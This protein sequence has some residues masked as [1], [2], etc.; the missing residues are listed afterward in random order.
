MMQLIIE[1]EQQSWKD[2]LQRPAPADQGITATVSAILRDI[3]LN[4]D[5]ALRRYTER[6]DGVSPDSFL[7]PKEVIAAAS[8]QVSATLKE[9]IG[10]AFENITAF[11]KAQL[12]GEERISTRPGVTCWRRSI[13]ISSAGL[14]IPGGTAPLFSTLLMLG[15]PAKL[16]GCSQVSIYSPAGKSGYPN[17]LVLYVADLLGIDRVFAVGG[18]QAIAAMAYGTGSIPAVDKIFGPGNAYVTEAKRLVNQQGIAIDMLAGPSEVAVY[19]DAAADP[20]FVAADLL[21]QAEHGADS[22]VLLVTP[23]ESIAREVLQALEKQ[24]PLLSRSVVA[25]EALRNSKAVV[26]NDTGTAFTLLNSYAPEHLIIAADNADELAAK[27]INAGS[28]FLGHYSP[29]SAGD[30]AS[31]TNHT[32]PTGGTARTVSGISVDSFMKTISFQQISKE[33]LAA[34]GDTVQQMAMAEGLEAHAKAV[35]IRLN[36]FN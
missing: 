20:G 6:F 1:P 31:G 7:V 34:I 22:Q 3:Q 18:A 27:V 4:G 11:H 35:S 24:L 12:R 10:L 36:S 2:I 23:E 13:P 5:E 33:G 19:A 14:Y 26:I 32:L 21:S 28:V 30:Y 17:P 15:I 25:S 8:S 16:A 29:E 9:S